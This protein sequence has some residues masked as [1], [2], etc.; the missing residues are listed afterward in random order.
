[1][2][3]TSVLSVALSIAF[4]MDSAIA[5]AMQQWNAYNAQLND[6]I[7]SGDTAAIQSLK[8]QI[9]VVRVAIRRMGGTA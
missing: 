8:Q 2:T 6:A 1:M 4:D 5:L 3:S 7:S 9:K